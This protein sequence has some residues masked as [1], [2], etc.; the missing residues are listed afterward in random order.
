[1]VP[2]FDPRRDLWIDYFVW[3]EDFSLIIGLT[4]IGRATIEVLKLNRPSVVNLRRVLQAVRK[5]PPQ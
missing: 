3:T 4:P 5:H 2:L 1:M